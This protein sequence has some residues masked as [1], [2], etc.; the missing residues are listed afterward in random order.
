[1]TCRAGAPD[2]ARVLWCLAAVAAGVKLNEDAAPLELQSQHL[3]RVQAKAELAQLKEQVAL[4]GEEELEVQ[5]KLA[6]SQ[7]RV[8][9]LRQKL[10]DLGNGSP[11]PLSFL[12]TNS[13]S[14]LHAIQKKLTEEEDRVEVTRL[15]LR[16]KQRKLAKEKEKLQLLQKLQHKMQATAH[17]REVETHHLLDTPMFENSNLPAPE[18]KIQVPQDAEEQSQRKSQIAVG[19]AI[20]DAK[21]AKAQTEELTSLLAEQG[22]KLNELKRKAAESEQHFQKLQ[23]ERQRLEKSLER[24]KELRHSDET[25]AAL[26]AKQDAQAALEAKE[27]DLEATQL[28]TAKTKQQLLEEKE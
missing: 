22:S 11:A 8:A 10:Q 26:K 21:F 14:Q 18:T 27:K 5:E 25:F 20:E 16:Q 24:S 6:E 12:Q 15:L 13:D 17:E 7:E 28:E 3:A 2:M 1:M 4:A 23:Q 19:R 9:A